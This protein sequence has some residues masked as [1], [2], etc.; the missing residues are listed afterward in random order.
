[1]EKPI[2]KV[3]PLDVSILNLWYAWRKF[4]KGKRRS[5]ELEEFAYYLENNLFCLAD[6][7]NDDSYRHGGYRVFYVMDNKKRRIAVASIRDRVV[8]RL[9]YE[10]LVPIYDPTFIADVWSC[11]KKKGLFGAIERTQ[12]LLHQYPESFVWRSDVVKFFDNVDPEVLFELLRKRI[13]DGRALRIL[14]EVIDSS[15]S[16][17]RA[18]EREHDAAQGN[19]YWKSDE[20]DFRQYL[21]ERIRSVRE[22]YLEAARVCALWR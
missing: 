14:R 13:S 18:R 21:F 8:H 3:E 22:E 20:S 15:L 9:L 4:R 12:K 7:L 10:Y 1:M 5:A 2:K 11:R 6:E 19:T 17:E 16:R